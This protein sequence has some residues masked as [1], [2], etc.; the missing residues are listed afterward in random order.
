MNLKYTGFISYRRIDWC[1]DCAKFFHRHLKKSEECSGK[2]VFLDKSNI[3]PGDGI[4][5]EVAD[6]IENSLCLLFFYVPISFSKDHPY[7]TWELSYFMQHE[8]ARTKKLQETNSKI[9]EKDCY[10]I[11]PIIIK[12]NDIEEIETPMPKLF[13]ERNYI[14]ISELTLTLKL[15][16]NCKILNEALK[17]IN[18]RFDKM[19]R[20]FKGLEAI[21]PI[22]RPELNFNENYEYIKRKYPSM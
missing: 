22:P 16:K 10:Q 3:I 9:K 12:H 21:N 1:S 15:N 14:D 20:T 2:D 4:S 8:E 19:K 6:A 17:D 7:C 11:I 13:D 18:K 5:D